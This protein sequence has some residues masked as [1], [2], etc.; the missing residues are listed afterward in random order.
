MPNPRLASRYAKSLIDLAQDSD[1]L[2]AVFSDLEYLNAACLGSRDLTNFIKSPVINAD[3][4]NKIFQILFKEKIS[5]LTSA[6]CNLLIR[7]GREIYLPEIAQAGIRQYR[8]IKN[9]R[10][11]KIT[12]AA[13]LEESTRKELIEK[14]KSEIPDKKIELSTHV[15][16]AL[17]GGFVLETDNNLFD[18]SILRDLKDIKKQFL[19]NVYVRNIR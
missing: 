4:K 15:N 16:E 1:R 8:K 7:K 2:E 18:A 19:D 17:V 9:I 5:P 11:V 12:T 13:P 6:F 14:I 3:K 10:Q